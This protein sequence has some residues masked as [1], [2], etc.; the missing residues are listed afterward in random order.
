MQAS[1]LLREIRRD[2]LRVR[3]SADH[4]NMFADVFSTTDDPADASRLNRIRDNVNRMDSALRELRLNK[5]SLSPWQRE[6][7][8]RI[9]PDVLVLTAN[10]K[11]AIKAFKQDRDHEFSAPLGPLSQNIMHLAKNVNRTVGEFK[12]YAATRQ[13]L[14]RLKQDLHIAS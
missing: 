1:A 10:A 14:S 2:A 7:V 8:N 4:L 12:T 11:V 9:T 5:A 3:E 6:A 13:E